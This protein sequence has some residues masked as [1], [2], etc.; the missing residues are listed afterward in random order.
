[1][2]KYLY[3]VAVALTC[4]TSASAF[5]LKDLM[6]NGGDTNPSDIV[7]G[8]VS[9]VTATDVEYKDLPGTWH[10]DKPAVS[11]KSDNVVQNAGGVAASGAIV[12]KLKPYYTKAGL[13][14]MTIEFAADSTFTAKTGKITVNGTVQTVGKGMFRFNIKALGKIPSGSINAFIEKQGSNISVTFDAKKLIKLA[15][16]IASLSGNAT[17]KTA[18]DLINSYEGVNIGFSLKK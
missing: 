12:N 8:I 3:F 2:K 18:S 10:Y 15:E 14:N 13:E 6:K 7:N 11:F 16:T 1:M 4:L 17:L 9:A 5:D